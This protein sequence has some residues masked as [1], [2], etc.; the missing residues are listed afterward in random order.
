M[1]KQQETPI[2]ERTEIFQIMGEIA[3]RS[4]KLMHELAERRCSG[5][6]E[7]RPAD[8]LNLAPTMLELTTRMMADPANL[9]QAQLDPLA[10][11]WQLWQTTGRRLLG[12][13]VEPV[14]EPE[15]GDRRFHDPAWDEHTRLRLHQAVLS[16]DRALDGR[17][18]QRA[19]KA[20]T[21]RPRQKID[22]YTRQFVDAMAPSNFVA[23]NPE[24]LR[25]TLETRRREPAARPE[26]PARTISSAARA[27]WRSR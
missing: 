5:N 13:E 11:Y 2:R 19:S 1:A 20:S 14:I 6:G 8:P 16:A 10:G 22:F 15:R 17:H 23:T 4:Q 27:S 7:V 26:E 3:E 18:G 24:V 25:A 9:M 12:Q 21:T